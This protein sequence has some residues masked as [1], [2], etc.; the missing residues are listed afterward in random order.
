MRASLWLTKVVPPVN[1]CSCV[2]AAFT[3]FALANKVLPCNGYSRI[4]A[5]TPAPTVLPPSR[6]AKRRP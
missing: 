5:T 2:F 4:L 6:T 1:I 3:T